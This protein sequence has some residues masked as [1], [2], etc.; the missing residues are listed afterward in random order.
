MSGATPVAQMVAAAAGART[1]PALAQRGVRELRAIAQVT[2]PATRRA[3]PHHSSHV[4]A[5]VGWLGPYVDE[6]VQ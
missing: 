5:A 4:P 6:S 1:V 2:V 3:A